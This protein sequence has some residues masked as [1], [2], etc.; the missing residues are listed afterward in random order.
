M[1][2]QEEIVLTA[3]ECGWNQFGMLRDI[4]TQLI[5]FMWGINVIWKRSWRL[6]KTVSNAFVETSAKDA[7]NVEAALMALTTAALKRKQAQGRTEIREGRIAH[8]DAESPRN[9]F[10]WFHSN[11]TGRRL[12]VRNNVKNIDL[13]LL[14]PSD[15]KTSFLMWFHITCHFH[16]PHQLRRETV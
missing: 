10:F 6:G 7:T 14:T 13:T 4:Q 12:F 11:R 2:C 5:W 9:Q 8:A 15:L 16:F 1:T 3:Q